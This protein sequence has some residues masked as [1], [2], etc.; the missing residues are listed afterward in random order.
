M[1]SGNGGKQDVFTGIGKHP[2]KNGNA[3]K[4]GT[5]KLTVKGVEAWVREFQ[6]EQMI[7]IN[8]AGDRLSDGGS[9]Y[10]TALPSGN[11][12]WQVRYTHG[13]KQKT[14]S[15][16]L[17]D[18]KTL[19]EARDERDK[20]KKLID[21]GHDPVTDRRIQR[22]AIEG[23]SESTFAGVTKEWLEKQ[24]K[25]W[26]DIHYRKSSQ[27]LERDIIPHLGKLPVAQI[28]TIMV[29]TVIEK[30]QKRGVRDTVAKI[31]Q[32]VR[33]IFAYAQSRGLRT[34]NPA[35]PVAQL[36]ERAAYPKH[37]PA[38]LEWH[39]LG[40]ILR[41]NEMANITPPVR[42]AH[43]LV[44]FTGVRISNA[45][46]A[47]RQHFDLDAT[48][49]VWTIPRDE[50]KVSG[51]GRTHPHRVVL[52]AQIVVELRRWINAQPE[53]SEFLFRGNQ[54]RTH[55]SREAI[56]KALRETLELAEKHSPH[57]WRSAFSTRAKDD[58]EFDKELV[59]LCLDHVHAS[60]TARAYDRGERLEKRIALM[61]WWG[62]SLEA[63]ERG[64][65]DARKAA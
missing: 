48:P 34:D 25:D 65:Y 61:K 63:A 57:G 60:D 28:T 26:S 31:F 23:Q 52:P 41:R 35:E 18:E 14:F 12:T 6:R 3:N 49:P 4:R 39:Q 21:T 9:L 43:R 42:M 7:G 22:L 38:L 46:E 20:I 27:A 44:A 62:D 36:L 37:H 29:A 19:A 10:L 15:I 33:A 8:R 17:A 30:I 55:I 5:N 59:D 2:S 58:T 45:V 54:G 40:D 64:D 24:S 47:R 50:M 53:N 51:K 56:E 13:G 16:G 32:H 1:K 11:A